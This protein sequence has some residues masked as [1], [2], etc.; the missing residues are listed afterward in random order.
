MEFKTEDERQKHINF[1]ENGCSDETEGFPCDCGCDKTYSTLQQMNDHKYYD[2]YRW[3]NLRNHKHRC[4]VCD[5]T[6]THKNGLTQHLKTQKHLKTSGRAR[7]GLQPDRPRRCSMCEKTFDTGLALK[8]HLTRPIHLERVR[9]HF[10]QT[11]RIWLGEK[12]ETWA[13]RLK[14]NAKE[15]NRLRQQKFRDTARG[16]R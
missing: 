11:V 13:E 2:T 16:R 10:H 9:F 4:C 15:A 12:A 3:N 1:I 7:N 5:K 14:K 8:L 6:F